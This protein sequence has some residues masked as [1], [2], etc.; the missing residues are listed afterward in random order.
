M[1]QM[2]SECPTYKLSGEVSKIKASYTDGHGVSDLKLYNNV[3]LMHELGEIFGELGVDKERWDFTEENP[4][5]GVYGNH[6][7][8]RIVKLGFIT[9]NK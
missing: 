7:Q 4:V 2:S 5:I 9:L 8:D 6:S 1:G 3:E